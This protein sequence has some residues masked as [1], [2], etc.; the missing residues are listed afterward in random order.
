MLSIVGN[1]KIELPEF[2]SVMLE[3]MRELDSED[4]IRKCFQVF[5]RDGNGH[6]NF[7]ELKCMMDLAG[8]KLSDYD[9]DEILKRADTNG[10]GQLDYEGGNC[11]N[12]ISTR[13]IS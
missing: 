6:I 8:T 9:I 7:Q 1:G 12:D 4:E 3:K 2:I 13:Y 10:D 5:D 11:F